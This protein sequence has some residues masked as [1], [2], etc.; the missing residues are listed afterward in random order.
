MGEATAPI[1]DKLKAL[2]LEVRFA[3]ALPVAPTVRVAVTCKT[4]GTNWIAVLALPP[5]WPAAVSYTHLRAH[6]TR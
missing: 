3:M 1:R 6:E 4:Q 5:G 2:C